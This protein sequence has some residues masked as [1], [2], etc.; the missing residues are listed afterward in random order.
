MASL[1]KEFGYQGGPARLMARSEAFARVAVEI[2][3]EEN[4]IAPVGIGAK[5]RRGPVD[6]AVAFRVPQENSCQAM[7]DFRG[8]LGK[9]EHFAGAR[10]EFHFEAVAEIVMK[11]LQ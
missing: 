3:V 1:L 5:L 7:R 2:F 6:R 10:R 8:N 9:R 11:L 4:Q